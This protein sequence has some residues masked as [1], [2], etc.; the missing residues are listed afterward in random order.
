MKNIKI[1]I[2]KS[3]SGNFQ[4]K[5]KGHFPNIYFKSTLDICETYKEAYWKSNTIRHVIKVLGNQVEV[6]NSVNAKDDGKNYCD[7]MAFNE[8][9]TDTE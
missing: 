8:L 9:G 2:D 7:L 6:L 4:I 1:I 5:M 3:T